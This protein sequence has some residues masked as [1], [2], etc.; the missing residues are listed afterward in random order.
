MSSHRNVLQDGAPGGLGAD[1]T[2]GTGPDG[3]RNAQYLLAEKFQ[4]VT[5][6]MAPSDATTT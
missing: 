4:S 1:E 5:S 2:T 6:G 3:R